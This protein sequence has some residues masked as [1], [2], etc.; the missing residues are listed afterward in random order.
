MWFKY[1]CYKWTMRIFIYLIQICLWNAYI[2]FLK[3]NEFFISFSD[4]VTEIATHYKHMAEEEKNKHT[5]M[6]V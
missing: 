3:K 4:F 2:L 6:N 1:R 5:K